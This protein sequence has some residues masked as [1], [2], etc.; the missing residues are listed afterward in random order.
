MV[1][2]DCGYGVS[3]TS[4]IANSRNAVRFGSRCVCSSRGVHAIRPTVTSSCTVASP[5]QTH[6]AS[7]G[8]R[9]S[10]ATRR[11]ATVSALPPTFAV[12]PAR[13][14]NSS[15]KRASTI[16]PCGAPVGSAGGFEQAA[17]HSKGTIQS[18]I[19]CRIFAPRRCDGG[20]PGSYARC[21]TP[22]CSSIP[23]RGR[24]GSVTRGDGSRG[25]EN[26]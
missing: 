5:I 10:P 16:A 4:S 15:S 6:T 22:G 26:T 2:S 8:Q 3:E 20:R 11:N 7:I 17:A 13:R 23:T 9:L 25:K 19:R 24:S 21:H 14:S 18:I 12:A 1:R